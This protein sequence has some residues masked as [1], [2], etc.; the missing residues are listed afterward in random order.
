MLEKF[1][2][3][4]AL[5][6][7][8]RQ[9]VIHKKIVTFDLFDT[10]LVRRIH[11]PD[12]VKLP[13]ARF[14]VERAKQDGIRI[15]FKK[16][17]RIRDDAEK[18]NRARTAES[19]EDHEACYPLFMRQALRTIWQEKF[20]E[21]LFE[22]VAAYEIAMENSMLVPRKELVDWLVELSDAGKRIF[23]ISDMYLPASYLEQ[24]LEYAGIRQY[25]EEVI[26]SADSYRAKASG[27]GY[28]LV[29]ERFGLD[30]EEWLHIG[31]NEYSDGLRAEEFGIDSL[32]IHDPKEDQRKSI[33]KR[34]FNYSDGK[35]FWRGRVLQQLMAPLEGEN[36]K[37]E[38]LYTEGYNF[39]GPVIGIFVM[40]LAE[41]CRE[42]KISKIFFLSREGWTFKRYW[43]QAMPRLYPAG[44]LPETEYL[45]VSR[46]ALAGASCAVQG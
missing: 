37:K 36:T 12:L 1:Y 34:Y 11:D 21:S 31:D 30:R 3:L 18:E 14:I 13:V 10:L 33:V 20:A 15:G 32:I 8:G 42:K 41:L 35:P 5:V 23:I 2:S 45:Y 46:M 38:P 26:S 9:K 44:D 4:Q 6:K 7:A 43:E 40:R 25:V 16:V 29:A 17:Q 22:E 28:A 19:H 39:I 24:L 27:L